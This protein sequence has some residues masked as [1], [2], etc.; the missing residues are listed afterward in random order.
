MAGGNPSRRSDTGKSQL[1]LILD[2]YNFKPYINT[3]G[4]EELLAGTVS[5]EEV[6]KNLSL[7]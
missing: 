7:G 1:S 4:R 2:S 5:S 3:I 6:E